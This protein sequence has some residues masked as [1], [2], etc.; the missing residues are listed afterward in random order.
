METSDRS[1]SSEPVCASN[2]VQ[3][4]DQPVG[5]PCCSEGRLDGFH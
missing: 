2:S 4:V 1:F 5:Y 3:G